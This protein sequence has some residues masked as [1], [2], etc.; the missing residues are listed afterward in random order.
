M[1]LGILNADI[2][3]V[4]ADALIYSTNTQVMLS[5]GVGACLLKKFGNEFQNELY[6]QIDRSGRREAEVGEVFVTE[7]QDTPWDLVCHT[8]ATDSL[9]HTSQDVVRSIVQRYIEDCGS[10]ELKSVVMSSLGAGYGDLDL[11]E[12]IRIVSDVT[13]A[14]GPSSIRQ[15]TICC[16]Q[17]DK[18]AE[19][20]SA[21]KQLTTN[22]IV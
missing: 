14:V 7:P 11:G 18:H 2:V 19:L 8:V 5:G 3:D 16:D 6:R 10:R 20:L 21:T 12:F 22:W 15:L 17:P 4:S 1:K 13:G 9:Y